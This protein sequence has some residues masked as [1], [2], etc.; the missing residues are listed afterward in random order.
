MKL[1]EFLNSPRIFQQLQSRRLPMLLRFQ[2]APD[3]TARA[4]QIPLVGSIGYYFRLRRHRGNVSYSSVCV[5]EMRPILVDNR[6]PARVSI[7]HPA[8][9]LLLVLGNLDRWP[10]A[11]A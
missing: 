6:E 11:G 10:E 2:A 1:A 4:A 5:P 7:D 8:A 3:G 9:G